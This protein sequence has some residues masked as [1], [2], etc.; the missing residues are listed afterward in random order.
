M[1]LNIAQRL[2]LAEQR[3]AAAARGRPEPDDWPALFRVRGRHLQAALAGK[4]PPAL[5]SALR[6]FQAAV[7]AA[8]GDGSGRPLLPALLHLQSVRLL[9]SH[10]AGEQLGYVFWARALEGLV[11]RGLGDP[12]MPPLAAEA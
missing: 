5:A 6:T 10:P 11:R 1:G 12:P 8:A 4:L 9:G 2:Q 3:R 7:R